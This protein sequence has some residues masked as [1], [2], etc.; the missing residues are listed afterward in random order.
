MALR[1]TRPR[2]NVADYWRRAFAQSRR[3]G[4][5]YQ[6]LDQSAGFPLWPSR[7][8]IGFDIASSLTAC[9]QIARSG[10]EG[11]NDRSGMDP[12]PGIAGVDGRS[13]R[14]AGRGARAYT[15]PFSEHR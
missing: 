9:R 5:E 2:E 8:E 15:S 12:P 3:S 14:L 11:G 7:A 6:P 10:N 4:Q 1:Q 13:R